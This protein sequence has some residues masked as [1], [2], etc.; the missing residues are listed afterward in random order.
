VI[1]TIEPS[2]EINYIYNPELPAGT[3]KETIK[4]RT[5]YVVETYKVWYQNGVEFKREFLHTSTYRAYQKTMEY[6]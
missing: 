2:L 5:G 3:S 6:N 4:L 1:K